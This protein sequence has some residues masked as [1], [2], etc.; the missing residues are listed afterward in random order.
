MPRATMRSN[1]PLDVITYCFRACYDNTIFSEGEGRGYPVQN[2]AKPG[3][4][5]LCEDGTEGRGSGYCRPSH[6]ANDYMHSLPTPAPDDLVFRAHRKRSR[7]ILLLLVCLLL[8]VALTV[9]LLVHFIGDSSEDS[10]SPFSLSSSLSPPVITLASIQ[11]SLTVI[12]G[13]FAMYNPHMADSTS[14]AFIILRNAFLFKMDTIFM[15]SNLAN[16]YNK[17]QVLHL[18]DNKRNVMVNFSIQPQPG[19]NTSAPLPILSKQLEAILA[20]GF[21]NSIFVIDPSSIFIR[22]N[23]LIRPNI[24]LPPQGKCVPLSVSVCANSNTSYPNFLHQQTQTEAEMTV[25]QHYGLSFQPACYVTAGDYFC[26]VISP[27]CGADGRPIPPC[28]RFCLNVKRMCTRDTH[29]S[30][31]LNMHS[32]DEFP[33]SEDPK[34]CVRDPNQAGTCV[35]VTVPNSYCA[36]QG[37]NQTAFPNTLYPED[38]SIYV[39][40]HF[41]EGQLMLQVMHFMEGQFRL[42]VM[43]FMEG[44]LM[45]QVMHFMEGQLMLQ[46]MHFM[47]GQLM[48]QVMHFME[49]QFMLQVMHFMEGQLKLLVMHFME[50]QFMLQVMHFMEGQFRLQVMHFMEGQFRLQVM[51]FMEGQLKLLVMHFM[52]GQ[53]MLQVMHFMEG[54]LMLQVMH[55]MEGQFML[56]V[57]HFMEVINNTTNCFKHSRL[58]ACALVAS[59]CSG[60]PP[61]HHIIPPC[62]SLCKAFKDRCG[63]FPEIFELNIF[64]NLSCSSLPDSPDPSVCVGYHQATEVEPFVCKNGEIRCGKNRCIKNSWVCDG[65]QD[66]DDNWDELH[67]AHCLKFEQSCSPSSGVC[68]NRTKGCDGEDDCFMAADE[69]FC[70]HIDSEHEAGV[71]K[72]YNSVS[73]E[74]E[75]VCRDNWTEDLSAMVCK[76][77]GYRRPLTTSYYQTTNLTGH[78][79]IVSTLRNASDP[80]RLQSY[81]FK[82]LKA[83]PSGYVVK[84]VCM[85]AACGVRP[86]YFKSPLRVVGGDEITPGAQPWMVSL[87]GGISQTFFCGATIIHERWLLTASHCIG[88]GYKGDLKYW[89][90]KAGSTRRFAYSAY[91]Q[92]RTPKA[93]FKHPMYNTA[94]VDS[95][96]ALILLDKPLAM[97]DFVRSIC[98][99][100]K[101]ADIGTRCYATG[102]GKVETSAPDYEPALRQVP[103]D[104]TSWEY[105]KHAIAMHNERPNHFTLTKNMM[106]AGGANA[107]DSCQGDSGG[108]LLCRRDNRSDEWYQG[109]IVSWGVVCGS[110]NTPGIYTN[111]PLFVHWIQETIA[112]HTHS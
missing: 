68:I 13:P 66:C 32:C 54:Q 89:K 63:V 23:A 56:Q 107:H 15:N 83:C 85:E 47:E 33:D 77:L 69:K 37:F 8:V 26:A 98:L 48:L 38:S 84:V 39:V 81:L 60:K 21:K 72:A 22:P 35:P 103:V 96:I 3:G 18:S 49:G 71:L 41:M 5:E 95:D 29:E 11:G 91:R 90:V 19:Y 73:L 102:W 6:A 40:M 4:S 28:R 79:S 45:L 51:H 64:E 110:P 100:D 74:W 24:T 52:E 58:F 7:V 62:A 75:E 31:F 112:N 88:G 1:S 20:R 109:G 25:K 30:S 61:P 44:Q 43:H 94:T 93:I 80:S 104:I 17:T 97:N 111:L 92:V 53:F 70:V 105:C 55:V 76:Q 34:I 10:S 16:M 12:A 14:P 46:V 59:P 78:K 101:P 86:A 108:P 57:M 2:G 9:G 50:G 106:C 36:S 65:F 42:Q 87:H 99:P 67:C 27:Q 82:G